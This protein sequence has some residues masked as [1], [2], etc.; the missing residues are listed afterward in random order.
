MVINIRPDRS[1][2]EFSP[3]WVDYGYLWREIDDD[4]LSVVN[5]GTFVYPTVFEQGKQFDFACKTIN[6]PVDYPCSFGIAVLDGDENIVDV[7]PAYMT[8]GEGRYDLFCGINYTW[9]S[10]VLSNTLSFDNVLPE[11]YKICVVSKKDGS[12]SWELIPG[13]IEAPSHCVFD[14]GN[15][16]IGEIKYTFNNADGV[17]GDPD[18]DTGNLIYRVNTVSPTEVIVGA[19]FG[20][21]SRPT[22]AWQIYI[23]TEYGLQIPMI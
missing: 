16:G 22:V 6:V 19:K 17:I 11:S 10:V 12:D 15:V 1:G 2:K 8:I 4:P 23:S 7:R 3:C 20:L 13:T 9:N 5:P 21:S 18:N 14:G